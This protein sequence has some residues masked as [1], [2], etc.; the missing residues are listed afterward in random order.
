MSFILDTR[1]PKNNRPA[2]LLSLALTRRRVDSRLTIRS[3]KC[4]LAAS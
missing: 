4:S 2:L 3:Q 1:K